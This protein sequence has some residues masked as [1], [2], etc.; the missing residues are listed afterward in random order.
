MAEDRRVG[1]VGLDD[2]PVDVA[3]DVRDCQLVLVRRD[4]EDADRSERREPRAAL[5]D[6]RQHDRERHLLHDLLERIERR[7]RIRAHGGQRVHRRL[8]RVLRRIDELA[9]EAR[10]HGDHGERVARLLRD[11]GDCGGKRLDDRVR[12]EGG[13]QLCRRLLRVRLHGVVIDVR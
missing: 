12:P 13:L 3:G 6:G 8:H 2:L 7:V 1:P 10:A 4:R 5:D 9:A 11:R